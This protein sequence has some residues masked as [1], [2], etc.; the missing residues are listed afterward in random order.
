MCLCLF[1]FKVHSL[2]AELIAKFVIYACTAVQHERAPRGVFKRVFQPEMIP[3]FDGAPQSTAPISN[4]YSTS[5][6]FSWQ[7]N[8]GGFLQNPRHFHLNL[9]ASPFVHLPTLHHVLPVDSHG[10]RPSSTTRTPLHLKEDEVSSSAN[11]EVPT[12]KRDSA[13]IA[14]KRSS[15]IRSFRRSLNRIMN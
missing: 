12:C 2:I 15:F 6:P 13:G 11:E 14:T 8:L 3:A 1:F 9:L 5:I 7:P 10:G 4:P